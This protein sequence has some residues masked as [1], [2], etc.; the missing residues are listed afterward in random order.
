MARGR[1][2][3]ARR[4]MA[5]FGSKV[6]KVAPGEVVSYV[7]QFASPDQDTFSATLAGVRSAPGVRAAAV[8]SAAVGGTSIMR[9]SYEGNL[10][11]LAAALRGRGF[12]VEQGGGGLRISR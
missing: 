9:V 5:V 1:H 11:G 6:E 3:E 8:S 10:S 12:T 7:V 4:V 2:E